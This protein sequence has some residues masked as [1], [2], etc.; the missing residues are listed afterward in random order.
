MLGTAQRQSSGL[1]C[2]LLPLVLLVL[3]VLVHLVVVPAE[4]AGPVVGLEV[5][6]VGLAVAADLLHPVVVAEPGWL[7]VEV[8]AG[9]AA[10]LLSP[11]LAWLLLPVLVLP[12]LVVWLP[13]LLLWLL[14]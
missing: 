14:C 1:P 2:W 3:A 5:Q 12:R 8:A 4:S 11:L 7:A 6:A 10:D 9:V 13:W